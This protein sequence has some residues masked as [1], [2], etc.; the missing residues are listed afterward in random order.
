MRALTVLRALTAAGG[1]AAVGDLVR[2]TGLARATADPAVAAVGVPTHA[3]GRAPAA[4]RAAV[5]PAPPCCPRCA[6][7]PS[8]SRP[9]CGWPGAI[10]R[11]R[12]PE[13]VGAEA[14][15]PS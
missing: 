13:P 5:L 15:A 6:R 9:T 7:R 11:C 10:C 3:A 1:R 12:C 8:P 2:A 4:T 14:R